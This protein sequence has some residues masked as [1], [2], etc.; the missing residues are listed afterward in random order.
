MAAPRARWTPRAKAR[1]AEA[2]TGYLFITPAVLGF[3]VFVAIPLF[4]VF[5]TSLL[6]YNVLSGA[7]SFI[8][9]D[10]YSRLLRSPVFTTV[11]TNTGVFALGIVP[12]NVV[13]GLVLALLVNQKLPRIALFR[14]AYFVPVVVSMVAWSLVW[15]LFLQDNGAVNAL[16]AAIGIDGPNWLASSDWA[17]ISMIGVQI[18]KS[19]GISMVILLAALQGVPQDINEAAA[20][21][22]AGWLRRTVS[23]TVPTIS[24]TLLLVA[25]LATISSLKTFSTIYALTQGGPG[26]STT[27]LGY[28]IYDQ[29]FGA[30]QF[31]FAS[32]ASVLLFILALGLTVLQWWTRKHW[33][34]DE[35]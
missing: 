8:G 23:I 4:F 11:L 16:L 12:A 17:M 28:Y 32:A 6:D 33:V 26:Y 34:I 27:T 13:L 24:P 7:S 18:L 14:T 29:A 1:A 3:A 20:I 21:D 30:L 22:G 10:N 25:M 9:L 2:L 31:G 5:R 35:D 19:V 15:R